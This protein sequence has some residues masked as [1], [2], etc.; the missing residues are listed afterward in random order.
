MGHYRDGNYY[1][2]EQDAELQ[3]LEDGAGLVGH[4]VIYGVCALAV[5]IFQIIF[6]LFKLVTSDDAA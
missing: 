4:L 6:G 3:W 5:G 1:R 2:G